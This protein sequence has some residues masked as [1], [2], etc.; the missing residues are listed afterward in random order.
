MYR[1]QWD[2]RRCPVFFLSLYE[3]LAAVRR[4]YSGIQTWVYS[5]E[6]KLGEN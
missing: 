6:M 5:S 4:K 1:L 2:I 3:M